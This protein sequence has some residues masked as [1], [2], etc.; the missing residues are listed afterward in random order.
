MFDV[1]L[2]VPLFILAFLSNLIK[3]ICYSNKG[4]RFL[5]LMIITM[6]QLAFCVWIV[7]FF[8]DLGFNLF[9]FFSL[10]SIIVLNTFH[11]SFVFRDFGVR[12]S[13]EVTFLLFF[14]I[15]CSMF[16]LL[17]LFI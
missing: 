9:L 11:N 6:I 2:L 10:I 14:L 15:Q 1:L 12:I 16:W 8:N 3:Y 5:C 17:Y 4:D 13:K 7:S